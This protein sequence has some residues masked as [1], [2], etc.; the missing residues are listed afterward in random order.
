MKRFPAPPGWCST[1]R[2]ADAGLA[3][4]FHGYLQEPI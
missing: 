1:G 2:V 4:I 3:A